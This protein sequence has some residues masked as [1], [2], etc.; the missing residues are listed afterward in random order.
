M[1]S[2][3]GTS[4]AG[5][6]IDRVAADSLM[7]SGRFVGEIGE[8]K[9]A[10][11]DRVRI[12]ALRNATGVVLNGPI[13][14]AG[15]NYYEVDFRGDENTYPETAL[16]KVERAGVSLETHLLNNNWASKDTLSR[17][18]TYTK[19]EQPLRDVLYSFR[20]TRTRFEAFQ[21]KPL[22]KLLESPSRRLLIADEVGLGK[23]IEA[24]YI[25]REL[26]ARQPTSFRRVLVVC[27][28][29]LRDKWRSEMERRFEERFEV[30]EAED[31]RQKILAEAQ[32]RGDRCSFHAIC[33][34]QTLRGR[35]KPTY[36]ANG[37]QPKADWESDAKGRRTLLDDFEAGCPLLDL[38]IVDEAH[39]MR[40]PEALTHRL[41]LVLSEKADA[42]VL[43]TATPIQRHQEDLF[44]LLNILEPREF[45]H[46]AAFVARTKTN[47]HVIQAERALRSS[48]P[49]D[50]DGCR[51]HLEALRR[52]TAVGRQVNQSL[53]KEVIA[54]LTD[55]DPNRR[56]HV[57]AVQYDI[58]QLNLLAHVL[59]RT[60]KRDV[61][62]DRPIRDPYVMQP[63]WTT[64]EEE[65][66]G[67]ITELCHRLYTEHK[68]DAAARFAVCNM[69]RQIASCIPA[70]IARYAG[71][72][73]FDLADE[74]EHALDLNSL[75]T[76]SQDEDEKDKAYHVLQ[77]PEFID[78]ITSAATT[79]R[80]VDSKFDAFERQIRKI[81]RERPGRKI[82][83]F[84]FY[85]HTLSYLE[86]RLTAMGIICVLISGDVPSR[87][88][89]PENDERG[90]RVRQFHEDPEIRVLLSSEVGSEGLDFHMAS[91]MLVN[92][93]LPWNP[94]VVEQRIGRLDRYGQPSKVIRIFNFAMPDTIEDRVLQRLY[95]RIDIFRNTIGELEPILGDIVASLERLVTDG[96]LTD[97]QKQSMAE[98]CLDAIEQRRLIQQKFEA[99]SPQWVG[100]DEY[101]M[102]Q[103]R[104]VGDRR[105]FLSPEELRTFVGEFLDKEQIPW[106]AA[107]IEGVYELAW[108]KDLADLMR[109]HLGI[110]E[111]AQTSFL[112][113]SFGRKIRFTFDS[114]VAYQYPDVELLSARHSLIRVI[115]MF[116]RS[117]ADLLHPVARV[118]ITS[119]T[120][121]VGDYIYRLYLLSQNGA[122][123]PGQ[124]ME[125]IFISPDGVVLD[126][127]TSE[128]LLHEMITAGET[129]D[130]PPNI[131]AELIEPLVLRADEELVVRRDE[132]VKELRRH[133]SI[134]VERRLASLRATY[135]AKRQKMLYRLEQAREKNQSR[136]YTTMVEGSLRNMERD[137][138]A[139]SADLNGQTLVEIPFRRLA[140]GIVR[141]LR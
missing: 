117:H 65:F 93:D 30:F 47:E 88:N 33:S 36:A 137:F 19:L 82:V 67:S 25:L 54:K 57:V 89:D 48:K 51:H 74:D 38:V 141:V 140:A 41:G 1:A 24:G 80:G 135:D 104:S 128:N 125:A 26:K 123:R 86:Q 131:A 97:A 7:R 113:W 98:Q 110:E 124:Y 64:D 92:Y 16:E 76:A 132:R 85:K 35:R 105:R 59:T 14:I 56:D 10:P 71:L 102:E 5:L 79:L 121:P 138:E 130:P 136:Q 55:G 58:N 50:F 29:A 70:T 21:F 119:A 94:M 46:F 44:R 111:Q 49:A 83:L 75:S 114:D 8:G 31:V 95:E 126:E 34:M 40:N 96:T 99:D 77:D 118:S 23:T 120:M 22:M 112:S 6:A 4:T 66:Y 91:Y 116:Y 43:M 28:A 101:F 18:V 20:A 37:L 27:P 13:P 52:A 15:R 109:K 63:E 68:G 122:V 17:I 2:D 72:N 9:F 127:D 32:K 84:S 12:Q 45:D 100:Q 69:Q 115:H 90:K 78:E 42:M 133:N 61:Q 73:L 53:L 81:D 139:R 39:H 87:P 129:W 60:R 106:R 62:V 103:V 107:G 108:S 134:Y 3:P 11:G